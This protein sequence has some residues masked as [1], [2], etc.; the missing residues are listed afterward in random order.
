M[1]SRTRRSPYWPKRRL[2]SGATP[3]SARRE[4]TDPAGHLA[5][6]ML[7]SEK[8]LLVVAR[9]ARVHS[10]ERR[11]GYDYCEEGLPGLVI[12]E[13]RPNEKRGLFIGICEA[14]AAFRHGTD[15][16]IHAWRTRRRAP[17]SKAGIRIPTTS[18]W[19][20]GGTATVGPTAGRPG[21]SRPDEGW[22]VCS[23]KRERSIRA[24]RGDTSAAGR[25]PDRDA[26]PPPGPAPPGAGHDAGRDRCH[27]DDGVLLA[28][29]LAKPGT[30]TESTPCLLPTTRRTGGLSSGRTT[31]RYRDAPTAESSRWVSVDPKLDAYAGLRSTETPV[32]VLELLDK[33]G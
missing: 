10:V 13:V 7:G 32:V 25:S 1:R 6:S 28:L 14:S 31:H 8:T 21:S 3:R 24:L 11:V 22:M 20:D 5:T 29:R 17:F 27:F 19:S 4:R 30:T 15:A 23:H 33:A 26:L 2:F 16:I 18:S 12:A 9:T